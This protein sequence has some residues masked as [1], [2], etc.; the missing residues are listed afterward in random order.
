MTRMRILACGLL[1]SSS[2]AM[3]N[4][5][6]TIP[7]CQLAQELR[8]ALGFAAAQMAAL[9]VNSNAFSDIATAALTHVQNNRLPAILHCKCN[10]QDVRNSHHFYMSGD[11]C[12]KS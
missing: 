2:M 3:A 1:L 10:D 5:Q 6:T 4:E 12:L 8:R 11:I 9:D 7:D